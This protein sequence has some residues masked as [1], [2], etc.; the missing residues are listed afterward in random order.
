M[1]RWIFGVVT[2]TTLL[3][4]NVLILQKERVLHS[5]ARMYLRLAPRDPRSWMQGDYMALNYELIGQFR[6]NSPRENGHLVVKLDANGVAGLVRLHDGTPLAPGE[7]LLR[8]RARDQMRLGAESY[9]FQE[10]QA[11]LFNAARYGELRVAPSGESVLVGLA[12][13]RLEPLGPRRR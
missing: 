11:D 7:H 1:R 4:L 5:G 12:N 13:D 9:L 3:A 2:V 10:G 6:A 8:Y